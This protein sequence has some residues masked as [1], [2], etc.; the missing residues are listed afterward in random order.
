MVIVELDQTET[1]SRSG[2]SRPL[3]GCAVIAA[4]VALGLVGVLIYT[5]SL[6]QMRDLRQ[7]QSNMMAVGAALQRYHDVNNEYPPDLAALEGEYLKDSSVLQCPLA[8]TREGEP[9]FIYHRPGPGA[10]DSF[11]MLVCE[12]HGRSPEV[13]VR[14]IVLHKD[15]T[16]KLE[17]LSLRDAM[18]EGGRDQQKE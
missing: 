2:C 18:R 14:R 8:E 9:S 17:T 7:C 16:L 15:G 5:F 10:E 12:C 1:R 6:P 11:E 3:K 13:P 4:V